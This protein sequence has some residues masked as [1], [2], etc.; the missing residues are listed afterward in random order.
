MASIAK[1]NDVDIAF[2][3]W[4]HSPHF[5]GYASTRVYQ[6]GFRENNEVI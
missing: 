5:S 1:A 4:A 6:S 3:T 2:A